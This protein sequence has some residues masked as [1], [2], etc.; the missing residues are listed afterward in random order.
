MLKSKRSLCDLLL[1]VPN[2]GVTVVLIATVVV[3]KLDKG[4]VLCA[5]E[6]CIDVKGLVFKLVGGADDDGSASKSCAPERTGRRRQPE[7]TRRR[8]KRR[9]RKNRRIRLS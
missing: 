6:D 4:I 7:L 1:V 2:A 9:G 5:V 8:L 3:G